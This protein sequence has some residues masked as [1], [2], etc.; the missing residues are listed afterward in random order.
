MTARTYDAKL[1]D[2]TQVL[3]PEVGSRKD[4]FSRKELKPCPDTNRALVSSLLNCQRAERVT[5]A[6]K[7]LML[8]SLCY[9]NGEGW[10]KQKIVGWKFWA[11]G[12]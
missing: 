3:A 10:V 4:W 7:K 9:P 6:I 12:A 1:R 8:L 2:T 5:A 11:S